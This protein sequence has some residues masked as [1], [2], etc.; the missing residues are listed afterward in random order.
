MK[1]GR[2]KIRSIKGA[3]TLLVFLLLS[4]FAERLISQL[5]PLLPTTSPTVTSIS[6]DTVTVSRVLD[7][8]TIELNTG[9]KIRY[10]GVDAPE[11]HQIDKRSTCFGNEALE[12][13]KNLVEGK[14]VT[15]E[16]DQSETDQYGRLLRY[17]YVENV[18]IGQKLISEGF[19][20]A[21]DYPPDSRYK[22]LLKNAEDQAKLNRKGLWSTCS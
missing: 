18:M 8:D 5:E 22:T 14:I 11:L 12:A 2:K 16:K 9:Q 1:I 6:R 19:A 3:I 10:I 13:N 7:G 15:L 20:R 4:F 21:K 17:V